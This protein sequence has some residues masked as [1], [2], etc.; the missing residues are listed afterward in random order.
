MKKVIGIL[1]IATLALG[2]AAA[3]QDFGGQ[4]KARQGQMRIIAINLGILGGMAKGE[5]AYDAATAQAAADSIAGVTMVA[6]GPLWPEGSDEMSIDGTKAKAE[7][8]SDNAGF[9]AKYAELHTAALALQAAA[10]QGQEA[11]GPALGGLG[12]ACKA[13]HETYRA[14]MN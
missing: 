11:I 7:I 13:C 1:G 8:W 5:I 12:G 10:G 14:P 4:L 6:P 3:A 9:L 2:T